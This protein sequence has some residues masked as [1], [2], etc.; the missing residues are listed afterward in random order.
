M[1]TFVQHVQCVRHL[2][3]LSLPAIHLDRY[4]YYPHSTDGWNWGTGCLSDLFKVTQSMRELEF[5]LRQSAAEKM[6]LTIGW[7]GIFFWTSV[8]TIPIHHIAF[9]YLLIP[10]DYQRSINVVS[11]LRFRQNFIEGN[12]TSWFVQPVSSGGGGKIQRLSTWDHIWV[13][14]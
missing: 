5:E 7:N 6:W 14:Y 12:H 3:H 10:C 1:I 11:T 2:I 4:Y 13:T 9:Y 8:S